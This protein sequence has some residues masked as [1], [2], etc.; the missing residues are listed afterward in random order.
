MADS[1]KSSSDTTKHGMIVLNPDGSNV[2]GSVTVD[3]TGLATDTN[4][5]NGSQKTQIVDAGGEAVTVT[6]GK[7]DV[8]A[9]V[10][11]TGL[12]L[13][14]TLTDNS[15]VTQI[16]DSSGNAVTVTGNKLDVNASIDTTGLATTTTD[17]NTGTIA[18]DTTSIDAKIPSLGQALAAG[19]VPVVLP[20]AQITTLTPQTDALT[21]TQLRATAVP[22]SGTF[23]QATQPVSAAS[24]PLPSGAATAAK[25]PALGTAGTASSDVITVQGIAS[26][27]A[28]KVDGSAV[29][30]PVSFTGSGDVA[31]QTTLAAINA[32]LVSGT[33]IGDVTINNSTGAA[34]VN[35]Q[36]G[37]NTITVDGTVAATQSGSWSLAANQSVNIAQMNGVTTTMGNGASGTGVQR[38]TI[39]SD[40][41]GNIATIG[42]SVTPGTAAANLGKAEDAAHSSGDVGVMSLGVRA[43]SPTER[44]AGPTDGDYEPFATNERGA[45]WVTPIPSANGGD[46][47]MNATSEDGSTALTNTAQVIKATAGTL[48][49]YYIYNPNSSATYVH[50]YNTAAASVTVGTTNPLFGLCI[51]AT[52]AANLSGLNVKFSNAGWSWAA[53]TTGGGNTAPSTALE[54]V[55]FYI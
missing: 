36:D 25:Q 50:F 29:T 41:T 37:G 20:A 19:S 49:G 44:S 5:T 27:T 2:G 32:K 1:I 6:G 24:L 3:P 22:V 18:S 30:Q 43:S 34:A 21:D 15:Q 4:Q 39:A 7:L 51:P 23:W 28:L 47:V 53:T 54:A 46:S 45:I 11:T 10:D 16:V 42:T 35:I 17:T 55:A 38:V 52:G 12:A 31:T 48:T 8:N 13:D 9:S 33:D 14:A 40:S 26:M